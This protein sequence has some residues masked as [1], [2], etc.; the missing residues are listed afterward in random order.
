M[1]KRTRVDKLAHKAQLAAEG[2]NL[3]ELYQITKELAGKLIKPQVG[4]RDL[5]G[6]LLTTPQNQL[7]RR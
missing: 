4:V 1:H 3:K 2:N 5:T 6:C 7:T